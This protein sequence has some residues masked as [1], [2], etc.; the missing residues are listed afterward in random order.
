MS[1]ATSVLAS[2]EW[3]AARLRV[4]AF[5]ARLPCNSTDDTPSALSLRARVL[6]RCLVRVKTTERREP[7]VRSTSTGIRCS[8]ST[9]NTWCSTSGVA[10]SGESAS[11][12]TGLRR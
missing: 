7:L 9:C 6:A 10:D 3:K 11:W 12:V 2:P 1:V 4:R 5:W 8:E